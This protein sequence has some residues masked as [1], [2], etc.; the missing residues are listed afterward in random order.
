MNDLVSKGPKKE[1]VDK[2]RE[3]IRRERETNL[4]ENSY[5]QS[6]LKTYYLNKNGDFSTY[7]DFDKAVNQ[8]S[9]ESLKK[10]ANYV[11]DFKNY[12]N[13]A[14]KPETAK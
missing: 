9:P 1:E 12:I 13:V 14:L 8:I 10:A 7:K 6:T 5:W 4:R 2:A 3:K 11:F